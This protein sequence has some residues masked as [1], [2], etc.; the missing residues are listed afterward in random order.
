MFLYSSFYL[1]IGVASVC[2][3]S[4]LGE[5]KICFCVGIHTSYSLTLQY[6]VSERT[7]ELFELCNASVLE[8][9]LSLSIMYSQIIKQ[10][11]HLLCVKDAFCIVR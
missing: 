5:N 2:S 4:I 3:L 7:H 10:V 9:T 8:D 1:Y 6:G 11:T